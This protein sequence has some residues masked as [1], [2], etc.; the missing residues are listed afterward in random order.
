MHVEKRITGRLAVSLADDDKVPSK[1]KFDGLA[2][3]RDG[4]IDAC[5]GLAKVDLL[6]R[7]FPLLQSDEALG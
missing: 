1:G 5:L 6:P 7:G 2:T 4:R 3:F